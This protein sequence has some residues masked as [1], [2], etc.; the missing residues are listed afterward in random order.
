MAL[1]RPEER[2]ILQE[3]LQGMAG[4]VD[5]DVFTRDTRLFVPGRECPGCEETVR[6][7]QELAELSPS[8]RVRIRDI[9][10]ESAGAQEMGVE[11]AP[12]VVVH[13]RAGGRV[14]FVG[15]PVGYEFATLVETLV[16]ASHPAGTGD[17]PGPGQ[18][19]GEPGTGGDGQAEALAYLGQVGRPVH[20]RVF[21][22]PT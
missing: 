13:G 18:G 17:E 11:R 20:L 21:F 14:R 19:T 8:L 1:I 4:P 22:T 12:T 16:E 15:P 2:K 9:D 5:V 3:R 7:M 10:R 6:L